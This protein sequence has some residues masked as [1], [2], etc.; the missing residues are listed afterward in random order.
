MKQDYLWDK[1]GSDAEIEDLENA[2]AVFCYKETAPPA[3]PAK[4]IPFKKAPQPRS[5]QVVYAIAACAAF[6][7]VGLG[8]WAQISSNKTAHQEDWV[9]TIEPQKSEASSKTEIERNA[10]PVVQNVD[11][12]DRSEVKNDKR[13]SAR[14]IIKANRIVPSVVRPPEKKVKKVVQ[15][16]SDVRLTKEEQYAYEQLMLAL[17]ITS[18]KLKIVK[19]K[20]EG[21][22]E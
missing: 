22:E 15:K 17:S 4:V 16:K 18:S 2:L 9:K 7:L 14:K 1:T 12:S 13:I 21:F 3:L 20:V 8:T 19:D 5:F 6:V 11:S 10:P